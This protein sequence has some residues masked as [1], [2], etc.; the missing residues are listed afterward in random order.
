[1][2]DIFQ[3]SQI[4]AGC[5]YSNKVF[6]LAVMMFTNLPPELFSRIFNLYRVTQVFK[7]VQAYKKN[8][9]MAKLY[10]IKLVWCFLT[11]CSKMFLIV[12]LYLDNPVSSY[13]ILIFF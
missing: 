4:L 5:Y 6:D 3:D 13:D 10:K 8:I 12:Q 2:L 11:N 7:K 9:F 1:M